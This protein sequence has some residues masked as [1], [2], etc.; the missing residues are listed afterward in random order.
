[1][2]QRTGIPKKF[3]LLGHTITVC[4]VK[5][6]RWRLKDTV[7]IWEPEKLRISILSGLPSTSLQQVFCH[8]W[9]HAMLD[10]MVHPLSTDEQFVDQ[11]AHLL[12]QSLTTFEE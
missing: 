10:M 9:T 5:K 6:H 4:I 12:Q 2:K 8:E 1:V 11:L 7:G 3:Q